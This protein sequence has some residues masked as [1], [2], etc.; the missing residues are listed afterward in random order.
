MQ[1]LQVTH[2][3]LADR[4]QLASVFLEATYAAKVRSGSKI[5]TCSKGVG[6]WALTN[7]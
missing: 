5:G 6:S 7:A 2:E 1:L 3:V 4:V